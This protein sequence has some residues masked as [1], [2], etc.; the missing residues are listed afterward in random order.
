MAND[1]ERKIRDKMINLTSYANSQIKQNKIQL[2]EGLKHKHL[3]DIT[4][5]SKNDKKQNHELACPLVVTLN[6]Y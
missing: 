1:R 3:E 4:N 5:G 6:V 2:E